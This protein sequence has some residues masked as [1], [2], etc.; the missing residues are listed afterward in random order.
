MTGAEAIFG[1][2]R[3]GTP[4][5]EAKVVTGYSAAGFTA[6]ENY[7]TDTAIEA[8]DGVSLRSPEHGNMIFGI[9]FVVIHSK[10]Q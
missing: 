9:L 7:F 10:M 6:L 3:G 1:R 5:I 8:A 2:T 4:A